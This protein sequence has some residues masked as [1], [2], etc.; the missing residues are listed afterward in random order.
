MRKKEDLHIAILKYGEDKLESGVTFVELCTYIKNQGYKVSDY[1]MRHNMSDNYVV[2]EQEH[3]GSPWEAMD[4]GLKFSLSVES[5]F[6]LIEYREFKSANKSSRTATRFATAALGMSIL[7]A[8]LS[9]YFSNKQLNTPTNISS[10]QLTRIIELKYDDS[11]INKTLELIV[12]Q[13]K[14]LTDKI[15]AIENKPRRK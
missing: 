3:Q 13:Q 6:R 4:D 10:D 9:I 8:F 11:N 1:R 2:M 5:T 14:I 7:S 15:I 12:T